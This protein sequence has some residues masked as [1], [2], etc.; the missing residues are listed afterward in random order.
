MM[1]ESAVVQRASWHTQNYGSRVAQLS[2][3]F[4][5]HDASEREDLRPMP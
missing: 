3:W 1:P 2:G 5:L 4:S